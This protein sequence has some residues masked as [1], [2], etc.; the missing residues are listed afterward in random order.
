MEGASDWEKWINAE[1]D[2]S[3]IVKVALAHYQFE[4]LH[5]FSDGNGRLGR[6]IATLQLI[7]AGALTYP[8]LNL[9]PWLE[10]RKDEYKDRLLNVSRTGD[11]DQWVSFFSEAVVAQAARGVERIEDLLSWREE[12]MQ[13]LADEKVRGVSVRIADSLL[14]FPFITPTQAAKNHDV[15]YPS[16]NAAIG[17]LT[18]LGILREATGRTYGRIF[19]CDQVMGLMTRD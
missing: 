6:L 5:P 13:R 9:S 7:Y 2:M 19:V 3:L 16:A 17:R 4:T 10:E 15:K 18:D 12:T 8:V 14:G 1:D 11:F